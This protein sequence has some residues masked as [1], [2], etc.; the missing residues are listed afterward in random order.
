MTRIRAAAILAIVTL[1]VQ[2]AP[3]MRLA[4][5]DAVSSK[6]GMVVCTSAP[7]CDAGAAG[8]AKGGN[9]VDAPL[10]TPFALAATLPTPGNTDAPR[11]IALRPPPAPPPPL[12]F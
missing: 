11:S 5:V 3:A 10:A 1:V 7:A 2:P 12:R 8:L 6:D 9:A 4:A